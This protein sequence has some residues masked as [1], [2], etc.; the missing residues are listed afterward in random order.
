MR[1]RQVNGFQTGDLVMA[2]VASGKKA[3]IH[4]GRVAVRAT[5]RFNIQTGSSVV[6]GVSHR[7]CR[8][9]Q[10]NDGYGYFL[11]PTDS[12]DKGQAGKG[13]ASHGA[14]SLLA[15]NDEVSRAFG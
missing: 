4:V 15:V 2:T 3:G 1:N 5:G 10:R 14:L 9:L 11:Q 13:R 8:V 6:Q 12:I 7:H